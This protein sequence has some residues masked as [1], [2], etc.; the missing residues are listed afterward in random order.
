MADGS[1]DSMAWLTL[2][3]GLAALW[4]LSGATAVGSRHSS[5]GGADGGSG[6]DG[7]VMEQRG[8][9]LSKAERAA[10]RYARPQVARSKSLLTTMV[11]SLSPMVVNVANVAN[12]ANV[13]RISPSAVVYHPERAS[14]TLGNDSVTLGVARCRE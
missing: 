11:V 14:V 1:E 8:R 10:A 2:A 6:G 4:W 5:G 3:L 13:C 7:V 9:P 12:G